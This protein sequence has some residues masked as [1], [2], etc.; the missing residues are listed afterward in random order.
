[1][2]YRKGKFDTLDLI[3]IKNCFAEDIVGIMKTYRM[4]GTLSQV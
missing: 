1:M 3:K 4:G 2:I